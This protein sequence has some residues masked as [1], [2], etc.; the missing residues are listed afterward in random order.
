MPWLHLLKHKHQKSFACAGFFFFNLL[1]CFVTLLS[2]LGICS[3]MWYKS[4]EK[5]LLLWHHW[6]WVPFVLFCFNLADTRT[7]GMYHVFFLLQLCERPHFIVVTCFNSAAKLTRFK[8]WLQHSLVVWSL[9]NYSAFLG[10]YFIYKVE[11]YMYLF[12][13]S[14]CEK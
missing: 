13:K 1:L 9:S 11:I 14:C 2:V 4:H 10:I 6:F 12:S 5:F 7:Y 8:F 3:L